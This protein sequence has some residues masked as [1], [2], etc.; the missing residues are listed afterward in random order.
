MIRL[1][2]VNKKL[3]K[4]DWQ[5]TRYVND[6]LKCIIRA[7]IDLLEDDNDF[8]AEDFLPENNLRIDNE[9]WC[10]MVY[11]LYDVVC[12]EALRDYIKPKYQYLLYVILLWW[13]E[14]SDDN[15]QLLPVKLDSEAARAIGEAYPSEDGGSYA[16]RAITDYEEYYNILFEDYDFMPD[17]LGNLI[18]IYLRSKKVFAEFFPDVDLEEYHDLMPKDLQELYDEAKWEIKEDENVDIEKIVYDDIVF[19]CETVQADISLKNALENTIND[20]IRNLL[21]ATK[22]YCVSDQTRRGASGTGKEAGNVDILIE[23]GQYPVTLIEALK[24]VSIKEKYISDHIDK[25]YKYDTMGHNFNFLI[26]YVTTKN[27]KCFFERYKKFVCELKYP[28]ELKSYAIN[29][30]KQH[31][32]IRT[33]EMVLDRQ[34][35]DT[36][37]YHIIVHMPD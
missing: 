3:N 28:Y 8:V 20:N 7:L 36:K 24:L 1:D 35:I 27:F 5:V 31:S 10:N 15:S 22:M 21:K 12:S 34:G 13:E 18:I 4:M 11:D 6:N 16:L 9:V 30:A 33:I 32:E 2:I 26:S 17:T 23:M 25:I 19:C 37:L 29:A 14:C